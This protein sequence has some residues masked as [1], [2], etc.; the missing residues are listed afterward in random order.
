V[1]FMQ[2]FY[3]K[4]VFEENQLQIDEITDIDLSLVNSPVNIEH[5]D[6]RNF[7][8][9]R[10]D[11]K[12]FRSV[13]NEDGINYYVDADV[14]N[15]KFENILIDADSQLLVFDKNSVLIQSLSLNTEVL[16]APY[17]TERLKLYLPTIDARQANV[18]RLFLRY[19]N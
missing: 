7:E 4:G 3:I 11:F 10:I 1:E 12:S 16:L 15:V 19:S 2:S 6:F 18:A 5:Q 14:R 17:S 9:A 8:P 13:Q